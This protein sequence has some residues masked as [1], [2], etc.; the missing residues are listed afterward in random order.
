LLTAGETAAEIRLF[1]LGGHF[2]A[3]F[4]ALRSKLRAER[5]R[6][7][8]KLGASEMFAG[9]F[10][11]LAAGGALA[12]MGWRALRHQITLGDLA[13]LYQAFQQGMRLSRSLLDNVG[14]LYA[15]TLYIGNLF[16]FLALEPKVLNAAHPQPVLQVRNAIRFRNVSFCY[17]GTDRLAL[18]G[19][20][21]AIPAGRITAVVGSNGAGKSTLIKLL[22]RFYDPD[23]GSVELDGA[24]LRSLDLNG[25]RSSIT[26]LFQQPVH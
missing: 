20:D 18:D 5:A 4:Q 26:V 22:C 15:N 16:E 13:M 3:A 19:L 25:L 11:L 21:L 23:L 8:A 17:P 1:G 12:W 6:L 24:D 2:H 9:L 10:A 14:Q 7:S